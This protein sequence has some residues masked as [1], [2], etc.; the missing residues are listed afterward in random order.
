MRLRAA[1]TNIDRVDDVIQSLEGQLQGLK[2][3]ARQA[4][5]FRNISGHIRSA[6][7]ILLHQ[8]WISSAA[9]VDSAQNEL[10]AAEK[11]VAEKTGHSAA[12]STAQAEA[13]EILP[14]LREAEAVASA[15]LHRLSVE[16]DNL[17]TEE[18]QAREQMNRLIDRAHQ[19]ENDTTREQSEMKE[20]RDQ[21]ARISQ[22]VEALVRAR[23]DE[24]EHRSRTAEEAAT[25][26]GDLAG[27]EF[28]LQGLTEDFAKE[29]AR[30]LALSDQIRDLSARTNRLTERLAELRGET[31]M[32]AGSAG[33][34][35][36]I[37]LAAAEAEAN[38]AKAKRVE[39]TA[40][41]AAIADTLRET[42]SEALRFKAEADGLS[43]LLNLNSDDLWPPL[44]DSVS[45]EAGYEVALG[46]ALGDDLGVSTDSGAPVYWLTREPVGSAP[47]LPGD[48]TPLSQFVSGP[49]ALTLRL[50]QIGVVTAEQG[51][52]LSRD[53]AQGQ[54]LVTKEGALWR[55][56]G[57]TARVDAETPAATRLEQRNHLKDLRDQGVSLDRKVEEQS[58]QFE[59]ARDRTAAATEA[60]R[61]AVDRA[62]RLSLL[63]ASEADLGRELE[64]VGKSGAEATEAFAAMPPAANKKTEIEEVRTN[65]EALRRRYASAEAT[66]EGLQR[67]ANARAER[68]TVLETDLESWNR[69]GESAKA[70]IEAL[71]LR[72]QE[73]V[74]EVAR[75]EKLPEEISNHR[76]RL[77]GGIETAETERK[78]AAD[79]LA[80]AESTLSARDK[81]VKETQ[82]EL[83]AAREN[84]VRLESNFEIA[85][86]ALNTVVA[87][88]REKLEC[89]PQEALSKS[90]HKEGSDLPDLTSIE[91]R[92]DRLRRERERMGPVNLRA[93]IEA[94]EI[95]EQVETLQ[96]ESADLQA[97]IARLRQGIQSLNR[98]GRERLLASFEEV[99]THFREL[100]E[101]LFGGGR[102]HLALTDSDDPLQ[103]GLEIMVSPPGKR[104]Q[105]MS[106][107]SGGEKA[108][109]ALALLFAV[110]M[111]NP[112]PI[113]V[114]DEV[115]APLDGA[116][117]ERFCDLLRDIAAKSETRFLI[118]THNS[119]TMSRVNR[120]FGVT[121]EEAGVSQVV[122]VDLEQAETI[123]EA[124]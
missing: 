31:A 117:V 78:H 83:G 86:Q 96:T 12:A 81:A 41:E 87:S 114:L 19:I 22:E 110:F 4:S 30:R 44:I 32:T 58:A 92:L 119:I 70:Q 36:P 85:S 100:F 115:D 95:T 17:E 116:N 25:L 64:E 122:S 104:L 7:A 118:I 71:G 2:R 6:E 106:L 29:E 105:S 66:R 11:E 73:A 43:R 37:T 21:T 54:R 39:A 120:L 111:T 51:E 63:Q 8:N 55:W 15:S 56:D 69:R 93:D 47:S 49:P 45:V 50:S 76:D 24:A 121:M 16:R 10:A 112:A 5:R 123:K 34:S 107:M 80:D 97:A 46:S 94:A 99:N 124:V 3:Q 60:V 67:E 48:A 89:E 57:F 102:A 1:E 23:E 84:R 35:V 72:R 77:M 13:A 27:A 74:D 52:R 18:R 108:L 90:D 9:E 26:G 42:E 88:I 113:C 14:A 82:D 40:A 20:A 28:A 61:V 109:T 65:T 91:A 53:L 101:R 98:E 59:A 62:Q 68:I 103:A 79:A 75:L 38:S 33:D